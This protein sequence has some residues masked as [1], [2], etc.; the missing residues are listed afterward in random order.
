MTNDHTD[1]FITK[2][3]FIPLHMNTLIIKSIR[4]LL[5][6]SGLNTIRL[7]NVC[8]EKLIARHDILL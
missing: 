6:D 3:T 2:D 8:Q 4:M 5:R 1:E 7:M